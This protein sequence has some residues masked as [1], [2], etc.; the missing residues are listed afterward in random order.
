GD[1]RQKG[2]EPPPEALRL[3]MG[4]LAALAQ[5]LL[6]V[7]CPPLWLHQCVL[8]RLFQAIWAL[9]ATPYF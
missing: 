3:Y 4:R 9:H 2:G 6:A 5:R 7:T 8:F 1:R